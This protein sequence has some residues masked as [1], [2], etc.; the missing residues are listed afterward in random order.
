[1]QVLLQRQMHD[2]AGSAARDDHAHF[3]GN[4]Q[5]SLEQARRMI[6]RCPCS[7]QLVTRVDALLAL[8]VVAEPRGLQDAGQQRSV[9]RREL[10]RRLDRRMRRARHTAAN[11]MGLLGRPV[12]ADRDRFGT[13]CDRP[14]RRQRA[15]RCG[16]NVLEFGRDG[17]AQLRELREALLVEIVGL[18]LPRPGDRSPHPVQTRA[19]LIR[20]LDDASRFHD[21]PP[22]QVTVEVMN[23][24]VDY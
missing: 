21:A 16:G 6:Q 14:H 5:Q 8:A 2:L 11:E 13:R 17:G 1:M 20:L 10:L 24:A 22:F 18:R 15:Q 19:Q 4:R 12:L 23:L 9:D 7:G 3:V